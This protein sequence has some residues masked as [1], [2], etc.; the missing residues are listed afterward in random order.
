LK[1]VYS[2]DANFNPNTSSSIALTV[3]AAP[4]APDYSLTLSAADLTII[5]GQTGTLKV[6]VTANPNLDSSVTF[7]CSG[8]PAESTCSFSPPVLNVAG[9]QTGV[10]TLTIGTKAALATADLRRE[11][12]PPRLLASA[13]LT[14]VL[15]CVV[16]FGA[17]WRR[18]WMLVLIVFAL[19]GAVAL[20][21]CGSGGGS[22]SSSAPPDPGTPAGT[23]VV[24]VT[25]TAMSGTTPVT[26]TA[27]VT[28]AVQ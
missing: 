16:P 2:G 15:C 13:V 22:R 17:K 21:G 19:S 4:P 5:K 27:S 11:N 26:H 10:A 8:L 12:R 28:L 20:I 25:A 24:T 7:A 18:M 3:T 1:A 14:C 9:G 6:V 23:S